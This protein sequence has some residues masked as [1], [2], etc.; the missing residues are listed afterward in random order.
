MLQGVELKPGQADEEER[1]RGKIVV[2]GP[3]PAETGEETVTGS[4]IAV[5]DPPV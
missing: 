5:E 2:L 4:A 3:G 1:E